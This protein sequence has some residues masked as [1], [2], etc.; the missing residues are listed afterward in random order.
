MFNLPKP[1]LPTEDEPAPPQQFYVGEDGLCALCGKVATAEHMSSIDHMHRNNVHIRLD[2]LAGRTDRPRELFQGYTGALTRE[3]FISFWG[4]EVH[5]LGEKGTKIIAER[6]FQVRFGTSKKA[7]TYDLT[8][9]DVQAITL[10]VVSYSKDNAKYAGMKYLPWAKVVSEVSAV[11][12]APFPP[13]GTGWWPV[14][15]IA[16]RDNTWVQERALL[17][18]IYQLL[19]KQPQAWLCDLES[20]LSGNPPRPPPPPPALPNGVWEEEEE[21]PPPRVPVLRLRGTA[22]PPPT[23]IPDDQSG[24]AAAE[25]EE[26]D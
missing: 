6:G 21:I 4:R 1:T 19:E 13:E 12:D 10:G 24:P 17:A 15:D 8:M 9:S 22:A 5:R 7:R 23:P 2:T 11:A 16:L 20:P 14:V 3:K 18:C 25:M 26:V